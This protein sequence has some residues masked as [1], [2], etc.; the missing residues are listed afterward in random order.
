MHEHILEYIYTYIGGKMA[1]VGGDSEGVGMN[2]LQLIK[3]AI[4]DDVKG[5]VIGI[6][7]PKGALDGLLQGGYIIISSLLRIAYQTCLDHD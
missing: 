3:D 2:G 5:R 1:V 4:S 7:T 6:H